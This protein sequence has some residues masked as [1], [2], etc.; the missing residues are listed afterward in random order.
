[1]S[2]SDREFLRAADPA[3]R[4]ME[5]PVG[6]AALPRY[7]VAFCMALGWTFV[8][9]AAEPMEIRLGYKLK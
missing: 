6:S 4:F 9:L 1:M 7:L 8:C 3:A 5:M 2:G